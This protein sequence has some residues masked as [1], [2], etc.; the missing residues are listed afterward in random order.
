MKDLLSVV[1]P[2]YNAE[3]YISEA[4]ASVKDQVWNGPVEMIVTDDG[5]SD[6]TTEIAE[7]AG[8]IVIRQDHGGA[9]AARNAGI[10]ASK[11]EW[12]LLLD[13]DDVFSEGA[14]EALSLPFEKDP[15]LKAVFGKAEDFISPELSPLQAA[16][17]KVREGSYD[18]ILPGCSLIHRT[19]F[20]QVG[21][22]DSSLNSA[23]TVDWMMKLKDNRI[24]TQRIDTV[25][26]R[27][28]LHLSNTG[29]I[30]AHSEMKN[31][32]ALLR[33]RLKGR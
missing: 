14:L 17:L 28:R 13:A 6:R 3:K 33:K 9:A 31:Y 25:T 2:A 23:E 20:E 16:E 30:Q 29:R 32:A 1:I 11:G 21:L 24:K 12:I 4:I 26:L 8:C 10:K 19:V 5:S 7:K 15:E 27:R 18:G 22:F